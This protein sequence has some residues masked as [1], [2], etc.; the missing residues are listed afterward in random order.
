V[1]TQTRAGFVREAV[2]HRQQKPLQVM[3]QVRGENAETERRTADY[4][5]VADVLKGRREA[6]EEDGGEAVHRFRRLLRFWLKVPNSLFPW[7]EGSLRLM[8]SGLDIRVV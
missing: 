5:D 6:R 7:G 3:H 1:V 8:S 4:A 2:G